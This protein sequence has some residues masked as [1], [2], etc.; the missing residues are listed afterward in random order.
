M[1]LNDGHDLSSPRFSRLLDLEADYDNESMS[2]PGS[3]GRS[4]QAIQQVLYDVG[5]SLPKFGADG[6]Y[7]GETSTAVEAYQNAHPPLTVD[8]KVGFGTMGSLDARFPMPALP[9]AADM[10]AG[11][12]IPVVRSIIRPWSPH[13]IDVLATRITLK[14]FDTIFWTDEMWDGASWVPTV[15]PGGGYNTGTEIGV[16]NSTNEKM[17]QTLY[18]EVLHAEQPTSHGTTLA[19]ESYA[20]RIG[21]E[22]SIALGL[23]GRPALRTTDA[24]GRQFA[25]PTKVGAFVSA[26]YPSVAAGGS[27]DEII[28]KGAAPGTVRVQNSAGLVFTRPATV[29]EKVD[30]PITKTNEVTHAAADWTAP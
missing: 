28:G 24:Q 5:H 17:A 1:G 14:S 15:F 13:T 18:H 6:D 11:W 29:G 20:Y 21:E 3:K 2:K 30:G 25:D 22:F 7:G 26:R 16:L 4:V 10:S 12:S 27:G 9:G 23:S 8:G 19:K